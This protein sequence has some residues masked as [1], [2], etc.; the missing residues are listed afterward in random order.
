M[1]RALLSLLTV[2]VFI[3]ALVDCWR[4]RPGEVRR[5][6]RLGWTIVMVL[7]P[8][9]GAVAY[10]VWGRADIGSGERPSRP[11]RVIAPDDDPEF[12]SALDFQ[13]RQAAARQRR[14]N[15][16]DDP[17]STTDQPTER[18]P[19]DAGDGRPSGPLTNPDH[20]EDPDGDGLSGQPTS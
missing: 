20:H 13:R 4:S 7:F 5:L 11:G 12:L 15:A 8:L 1:A 17:P 9:I 10:L 19:D 18:R 16:A 2:A 3:Y 14:L 6:S